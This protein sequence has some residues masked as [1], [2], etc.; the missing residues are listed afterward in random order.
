MKR[1]F[2]FLLVVVIAATALN[3]TAFAYYT[4]YG[5]HNGYRWDGTLN[6][7]R[8]TSFT[9]FNWQ[10]NTYTTR[11]ILSVKFIDGKVFNRRWD[12]DAGQKSLYV[13]VSVPNG[14]IT[15]DATAT[16]KIGLSDVGSLYGRY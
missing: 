12:E 1:F 16:Y 2:A 7:G 14:F 8:Q 3:I 15:Y 9:T 10:G 6:V 4:G 5:Y 11:C 13:K